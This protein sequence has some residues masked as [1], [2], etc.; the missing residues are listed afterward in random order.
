MVAFSEEAMKAEACKE[1]VERVRVTQEAD[2]SEA[3]VAAVLV[4]VVR[5]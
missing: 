4:V 3:V 5:A 1:E 2:Y